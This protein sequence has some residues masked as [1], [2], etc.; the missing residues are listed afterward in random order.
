MLGALGT[1][2]R[3]CRQGEELL[4]TRVTGARL[5]GP[6]LP[7]QLVRRRAGEDAVTAVFGTET[8]LDAEEDGSTEAWPVLGRGWEMGDMLETWSLGWAILSHGSGSKGCL[9]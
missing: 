9:G 6:G 8:Q 3:G 1:S 4:E 2:P 5:G 7:L